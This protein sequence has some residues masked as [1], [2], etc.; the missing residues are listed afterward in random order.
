MA[1]Q[2]IGIGTTDNDG[3]GDPLRT[4]FG[5]VNDNFTELYDAAPSDT[6]YASSWDGVTTIAPSKNAVYDKFNALDGG[7]APGVHVTDRWY[8]TSVFGSTQASS[9]AGLAATACGRPVLIRKAITIK[10]LGLFIHTAG[11]GTFELAIYASNTSTG[12][13]TGTPLATVTGI[14]KTSA[15]TFVAAN[16]ASNLTLQPGIYLIFAMVS[17]TDGTWQTVAKTSGELPLLIGSSATS[18]VNSSTDMNVEVTATA[19]TYGTWPDM[20]SLTQTQAS[21]NIR[22][23]HVWLKAA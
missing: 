23:P 2:T 5:K 15:N 3:T 18:P 14:A 8:P 9:S 1:K 7:L 11:T 21:N 19:A 13:A 16:L 17:N 4:A 20:T 6:A 12:Y 22:S 10:A